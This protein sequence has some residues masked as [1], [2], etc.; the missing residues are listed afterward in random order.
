MVFGMPRSGAHAISPSHASFELT[1][2]EAATGPAPRTKVRIGSCPAPWPKSRP[3]HSPL[4]QRQGPAFGNHPGLARLVSP[5][6]MPQLVKCGGIGK[7]APNAQEPDLHQFGHGVRAVVVAPVHGTAPKT[8]RCHLPEGERM[9][10]KPLRGSEWLAERCGRSYEGA[11]SS[12][13]LRCTSAK[14]NSAAMAKEGKRDA[15]PSM[16]M[17][18]PITLWTW[19]AE[20]R[21]TIRS[22]IGCR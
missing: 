15:S 10:I 8:Q 7:S 9:P 16:P 6:T 4:P 12:E 21:G 5:E 11:R 1:R 19:P 18:F 14:T 13:K 3:G 22:V 20:K 17:T 2:P